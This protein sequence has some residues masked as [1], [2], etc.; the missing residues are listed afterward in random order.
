MKTGLLRKERGILLATPSGRAVRND[1]V[2]LWWDLAANVPPRRAQRLELQATVLLLTAVAAQLPEDPLQFATDWLEKFGYGF[3]DGLPMTKWTARHSAEIA[4]T[5]LLR[6]GAIERGEI[7][8][9]DRATPQGALFAR[10][11]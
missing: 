1:P 5:V 6:T 2:K 7:L 4:Y 3:R 9:P 10:A 11:R 8:Q